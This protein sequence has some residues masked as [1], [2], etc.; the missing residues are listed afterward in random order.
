MLI[1]Y[2]V[3]YLLALKI[4][5]K[6]SS[7]ISLGGFFI[8]LFTIYYFIPSL[9]QNELLKHRLFLDKNY[10]N[11]I[12]LISF[13][14][15]AFIIFY[16]VGYNC[17]THFIYSIKLRNKNLLYLFFFT[18]SFLVFLGYFLVGGYDNIGNYGNESY[19]DSY[20]SSLIQFHIICSLI[21]GL[22]CCTNKINYIVLVTIIILSLSIFAIGVRSTAV[23]L[24]LP[25]FFYLFYKESNYKQLLLLT[26][27][28]IFLFSVQSLRGF[29]RVGLDQVSSELIFHRN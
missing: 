26:L 28:Y 5:L 17:K 6:R 13:A 18:S 4:I 10:D 27:G 11:A 12:A 21:L 14:L 29:S 22:Y 24:L 9:F 8:V 19:S 3:F 2:V 25:C 20:A 23:S 1:L 16:K 7:F 15:L